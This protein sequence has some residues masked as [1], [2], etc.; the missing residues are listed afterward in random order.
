MD[1]YFNKIQNEIYNKITLNK[2]IPV[3]ILDLKIG[4]KILVNFYPYSQKHISSLHSKMGTIKNIEFDKL[5]DDV[6][7]FVTIK[8]YKEEV[9]N[10]LH[11]G[12]SYY[13]DT[14]GYNYSIFLIK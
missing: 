6:T 11:E 9:E 1:S 8:N 10:L 5:N 4:D 3:E 14:L 7:S 13:G 12:I 2:L